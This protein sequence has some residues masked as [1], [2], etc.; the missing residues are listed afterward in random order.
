MG[1][2][3]FWMYAAISCSYHQ[4]RGYFRFNR[5]I[6]GTLY[7]HV[8]NRCF[9]PHRKTRSIKNDADFMHFC[10]LLNFHLNHFLLYYK[11]LFRSL[12]CIDN[13][14]LDSMTF[15][16]HLS[17]F[18]LIFYHQSFNASFFPR[19]IY[20][21]FTEFSRWMYQ[22]F[23]SSCLLLKWILLKR[24]RDMI[25]FRDEINSY[26]PSFFEDVQWFF[27]SMLKFKNKQSKI[28]WR[29]NSL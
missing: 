24:I 11:F 14:H 16:H 27:L 17:L 8:Y 18:I 12:W 13:T 22:S 15:M 6:H 1:W 23:F 2:S 20:I 4:G 28:W 7:Y 9:T 21:N 25:V 26:R 29:Y 10:L 5:K 19:S 3:A